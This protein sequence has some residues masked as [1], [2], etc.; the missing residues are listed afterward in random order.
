MKTVNIHDAKTNLSK[1]LEQVQRGEE[2]IIAKAG[3][4][5]AELKLYVPKPSPIKFGLLKG[6]ITI[7]EDFDAP[8]PDIIKIFEESKLFPDE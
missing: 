6:Q 1:L 4:P 8:D 2:V 7:P 5:I 3:H